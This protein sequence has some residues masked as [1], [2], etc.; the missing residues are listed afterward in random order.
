MLT[1]KNG[2]PSSSLCSTKRFSRWCWI[3]KTR[4]SEKLCT[5]HEDMHST[6]WNKRDFYCVFHWGTMSDRVSI[7]QD[8]SPCTLI[9]LKKTCLLH[10]S[11]LDLQYK[12]Q[13][14]ILYTWR[15]S[16][17]IGHFRPSLCLCLVPLF[18]NLSYENEH[19]GGAHFHFKT[20]L[21]EAK[22]NSEMACYNKSYQS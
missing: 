14:E 13:Y 5:L 2:N 20:C 4:P 19:V 18:Q 7:C 1:S 9:D 10:S 22:G 3:L 11:N 16:T 12:Y 21:T 17:Q 6:T 15:F 8:K